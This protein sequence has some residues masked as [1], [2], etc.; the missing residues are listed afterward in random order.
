MGNGERLNQ[1]YALLQ[2]GMDETK[3]F[4]QIFGE[5]APLDGQLLEYTLKFSFTAALFKSSEQ[6]EAKSYAVRILTP[7][8]SEAELGLF[9]FYRRNKE[10]ARTS[11]EASLQDDPKL[12]L[13]HEGMGFLN[14][15]EGKD[16]D[17]IKE[18][19][20]AYDLDHKLY[21]SLFFKT[22]ME[23]APQDQTDFKLTL[24]QILNANHNFAPV[25]VELSR[26][27]LRSGDMGNAL[28][29]ARKAAQLEPSRAGYYLLVGRILV[30]ME[31]GSE[32]TPIAKF[33]A[34]RWAGPDH[35]EAVELW[36]DVPLAQ[37][38]AGEQIP[39][40]IPEAVESVE[41]VLRSLNCGDKD[42]KFQL[43][44]E[45]DGQMLSLRAEGGFGMGYSDTIWYG[46]D[47]FSPCRHLQGMHVIVRYKPASDKSYGGN[48]AELEV[49][50]IL[51]Q[52][53]VAE[54]AAENSNSRH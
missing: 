31:K 5:F 1:Y 2:Q 18:F 4:K 34:A 50:E 15:Q 33:V 45:H 10:L 49:R 35:N 46:R 7:A 42:H 53:P 29:M 11:F 51:P 22:M 8:E 32:A 9:Y 21:L 16:E 19:S 40:Q 27:Y 36:N 14:F 52:A 6:Q 38:P 39:Y 43:T 48:L 23:T 37:R 28:L 24:L 54:K 13:A 3:A 20:Q 44:V 25:Y 30:R 47:H 17:A 26:M 41:G 12:G